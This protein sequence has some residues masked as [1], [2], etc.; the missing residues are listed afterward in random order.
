MN[1]HLKQASVIIRTAMQRNLQYRFTVAMY[2]IG[3]ITEIIVLILMWTAIYANNTGTIRGFTLNEMLTYVIIG[4]LC[5]VITRNFLPGLVAHDIVDGRLSMFLVRP[6]SYIKYVMISEI[7]RILL[8]TFLSILSLVA[9]LS[10]FSDKIV[11]NTDP[12]YLCVIAIMIFFA[13]IIEMLIGLLIGMIGFWTDDTDGLQA[14]IERVKRFFSGGYF[15]LSLLPVTLATISI[16]LPF[17]YSFFTP[18]S[19]YLKKTGL[20]AGIHGILIQLIWLGLLSL[21][22]WF[23]WKKGLKKYEASGS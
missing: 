7:G 23:T 11:F 3:E 19:L 1:R 5:S 17:T 18:A 6:I 20:D 21:L 12:A 9:I 14:T 16:Y 10:F 4:N 8:S 2:R 15:P 22:I 13:F